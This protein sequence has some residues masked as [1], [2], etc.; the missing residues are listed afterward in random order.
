[1]PS[2]IELDVTHW[3]RVS[4][5]G[6]TQKIKALSFACF[7]YRGESSPPP[8]ASEGTEI[9]ANGEITMTRAQAP[10]WFRN[11]KAASTEEQKQSILELQPVEA[12]NIVE[13]EVLEGS[14]TAAKLAAKAVEASKALAATVPVPVAGESLTAVAGTAGVTRTIN[15]AY[16]A[17]AEASAK[18][19][20]IHNLGTTAVVVTAWT[21]ASKIPS[22]VIAFPA[23]TTK[24]GITKVKAESANEVLVTLNG[25]TP[26]AKEEFIYIVTG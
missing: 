4:P 10:Y 14:I 16:T 18:V 5:E 7:Y 15:F 25:E 13:G 12:E 21:T 2:P 11:K 9:A 1:M 17:K 20:L 22:E 23:A 3:T 19:K 6:R 8:L 26:G 24:G